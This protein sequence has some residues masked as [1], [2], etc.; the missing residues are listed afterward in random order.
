[1]W[2]A[3]VSAVGSLLGA[4]VSAWGQSQAQDKSEKFSKE[5]YDY[6][7]LHGPSLEMQG[8][9]AAGINPMFR[10]GS[11]GS[12]TPVSVP[13]MNFGNAFGEAGPIIGNAASSAFSAMRTEQDIAES[14]QRIVNMQSE[15]VRIGEDV[16][17]IQADTSLTVQER[18][19]RIEE[20]ARTVQETLLATAQQ[21]LVEAQASAVPSQIQRAYAE[22]ALLRAQTSHES[23]RQLLTTWTRIVESF[24]ANMAE[25]S[26]NRAEA[27]AEVYSG[28]YGEFL[29]Y[30]GET[31]GSI[32]NIFG[33][34]NQAVG[35]FGR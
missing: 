2:P 27:D 8:L 26:L 16:R 15:A 25:L 1:M 22:M 11:G 9:K 5:M 32:G 6:A 18:N 28:A 29:R 33:Q 31:T 3:I 17:R 19:N 20:A 10:Y 14:G 34:G 23:E 21:R 30:L 12:S 35:L 13:V 4:G 7:L 24:R